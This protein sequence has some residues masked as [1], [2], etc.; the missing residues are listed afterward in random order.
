MRRLVRMSAL[1][2]VGVMAMSMMSAASAKTLINDPFNGTGPLGPPWKHVNATWRH[3]SGSVMVD[4]ASINPVTNVGYATRQLHGKKIR[5]ITIQSRIKLSP[6]YSNVG[7]V[8]P[9]ANVENHLFCKV[10]LS[11]AHRMGF[12]AI[13]RRLK[14]SAP[15]V[16]VFQ[17]NL[18]LTAGTK[19][20][21]NLV[22]A[23]RNITCSLTKGATTLTTINY[24]MT[25]QDVK[26]YGSGRKVGIRI[27][28]KGHGGE[29]E[30]DGRS[31]FNNFI[32]HN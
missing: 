29:G 11:K 21:L 10:E 26:A 12:L 27:R 30:D 31:R 9:Y 6:G 23:R 32:V 18:N 5:D 3:A 7:V 15:T 24:H 16:R 22:R 2:L 28:L 25:K 1:A 14:G 8:G 19:Y 4:I 20:R 17:K 13:G